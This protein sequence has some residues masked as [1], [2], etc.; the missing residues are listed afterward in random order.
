[1]RKKM[2]KFAYFLRLYMILNNR[3]TNDINHYMI[4]LLS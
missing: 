2:I 1:M 4:I 3:L